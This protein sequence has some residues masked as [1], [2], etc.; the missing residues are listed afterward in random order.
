MF[1][2]GLLAFALHFVPV[3]QQVDF[4]ALAPCTSTYAYCVTTTAPVGGMLP[5]GTPVTVSIQSGTGFT[6]QAAVVSGYVIWQQPIRP[7]AYLISWNGGYVWVMLQ[8]EGFQTQ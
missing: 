3:Q 1:W 4:T 7:P 2:I 5:I 6:Q 8:R